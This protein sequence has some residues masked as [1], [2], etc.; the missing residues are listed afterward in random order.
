MPKLFQ[1]SVETSHKKNGNTP[2]VKTHA[3][4]EATEWGSFGNLKASALS[5]GRRESTFQNQK[6]TDHVLLLISFQIAEMKKKHL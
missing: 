1:E 6:E 5:S 2:N 3:A 4:T